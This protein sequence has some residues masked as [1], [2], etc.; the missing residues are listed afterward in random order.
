[1]WANWEIVAFAEWIRK[2]NKYRRKKAGF[3]VPTVLPR[4]YNA[5]LYVDETQALHPL[6]VKPEELR[7]PDLYPWGV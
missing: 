2:Y 3:Y 4:R 6:H 5:F 7:P 1:M